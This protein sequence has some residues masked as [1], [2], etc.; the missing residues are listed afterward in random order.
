MKTKTIQIPNPKIKRSE[1]FRPFAPS[2]F[3]E[4]VNALSFGGF[5]GYFAD[6]TVHVIAGLGPA[7]T[8]VDEARWRTHWGLICLTH[9]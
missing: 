5:L 4:A 7:T 9:W 8:L 3:E 2:I 1:L 6:R